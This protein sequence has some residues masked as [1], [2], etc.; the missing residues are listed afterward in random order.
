MTNLDLLNIRDVCI[1]ALQA[2]M[3]KDF[4]DADAVNKSLEAIESFYNKHKDNGNKEEKP[5]DTDEEN[6]H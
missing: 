4:K 1:S 3:F 2:G 5:G 6:Q